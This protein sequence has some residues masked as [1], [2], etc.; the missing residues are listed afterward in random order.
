[1]DAVQLSSEVPISAVRRYWIGRRTRFNDQCEVQS[2]LC[3][4]QHMLRTDILNRLWAW[5]KQQNLK[6]GTV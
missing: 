5:T 1:M 3:Y 6:C 2:M 4:G